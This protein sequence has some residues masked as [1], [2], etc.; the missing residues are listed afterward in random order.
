[1]MKVWVGIF[2]CV[3]EKIGENTR[4]SGNEQDRKYEFYNQC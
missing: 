4:E 1:M 3:R 2:V